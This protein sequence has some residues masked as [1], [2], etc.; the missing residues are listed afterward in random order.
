MNN[1]KHRLTYLNIF[2]IVIILLPC[3]SRAS[4]IIH[5]LTVKDQIDPAVSNYIEDGIRSAESENARAIIII[6]DTPGGLLTSTQ[7]IIKD[8]FA[9]KV[10]VI[11]FIYPNGA[12]AASAGTFITM[13]ADIAAMAPVTN[14]G[15][16][17]PV[18]IDPSGSSKE[19]DPVMR[20][21]VNNYAAE[22]VRSIADKRGRNADWA[23]KAV[24]EAANLKSYAALKEHV[25]DY[26][27][28]DVPDLLKQID[29]KKLTLST[30]EKIVLSTK[31]VQIKDVQM[32][33]WTSFLHFLSNPIVA[34]FLFLLAIYGIIYELG[35]PGAILPGV[36]G[37]ISLILILYSFSVIPVSA[38]GLALVAFAIVL[39][40]AELFAP[41]IGI[42]AAGGVVSM[43]LGMM[44]I[45]RN[46]EGFMVPVWMIATSSIVTGAFFLFVV[47]M[48]IRALRK[49]FVTGKEALKG[50]VGEVR[51]D[52]NP[53]GR[54]FVDGALW[55]AVS[56][57]G[58][59]QKGD[60]V[61]V[62]SVEGLMLYVRRIPENTK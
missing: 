13:A 32:D 12:T 59:I 17:S 49:P 47:G 23:V 34:M 22:Y 62:A 44:M 15:S 19:M 9:S 3:L 38:A 36:V 56:L 30:G 40:V 29:G 2:L 33:W 24:R 26:V 6:M 39:F 35:T 8:I 37:G 52:L 60:E 5:Q 50:M 42:L 16:A 45:F 18:N 11:V 31:D 61:S 48:G 14:I 51:A 43:F 41:G 25:I 28:T 21:K 53:K 4:G 10:P 55:N 57:D 27:A 7:D 54:I 58:D 1:F 46:T 20:K